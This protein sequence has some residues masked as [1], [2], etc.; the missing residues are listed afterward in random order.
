MAAFV[1]IRTAK[2]GAAGRTKE[3]DDEEEKGSPLLR[4]GLQE[5]RTKWLMLVHLRLRW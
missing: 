5:N 3:E 2:P 1:R 4:S